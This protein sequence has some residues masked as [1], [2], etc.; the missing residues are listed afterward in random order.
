VLVIPIP[1][2]EGHPELIQAAPPYTLTDDEL[3]E[4]MRRLAR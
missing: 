3:D 4:A 2:S 1:A